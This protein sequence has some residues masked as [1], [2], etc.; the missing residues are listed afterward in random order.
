MRGAT[1]QVLGKLGALHQLKPFLAFIYKHVTISLLSITTIAKTARST[2]S[3][4]Y[5]ILRYAQDDSLILQA[6]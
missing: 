3:D 4:C 6:D 2:A 5:E 1:L